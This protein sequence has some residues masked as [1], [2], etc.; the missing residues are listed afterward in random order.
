MTHMELGVKTGM[1]VGLPPQD[2]G[3][4]QHRAGR[5]LLLPRLRPA[6]RT[7]RVGD[8]RARLVLLSAL[9]ILPVAADYDKLLKRVEKE[10]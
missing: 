7:E 4:G 10:K 9:A 6:L 2:H 1:V 8:M 5:P 3:P